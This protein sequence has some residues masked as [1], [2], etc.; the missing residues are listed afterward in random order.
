MINYLKKKKTYNDSGLQFR[1]Q[2][3]DYLYFYII[4][5]I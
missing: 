4:I 2:L 5:L 3:C 1:Q